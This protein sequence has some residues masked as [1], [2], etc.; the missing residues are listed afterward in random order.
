ML[1]YKVYI[2][3]MFC[4]Q[5][6]KSPPR[7]EPTVGVALTRSAAREEIKNWRAQNPNTKFRIR[8]YE[9]ECLRYL[10]SKGYCYCKKFDYI[11]V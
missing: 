2:I 6:T 8:K 11:R 3:E 7:W 4:D 10:Y 5:Y 9:H 1:K